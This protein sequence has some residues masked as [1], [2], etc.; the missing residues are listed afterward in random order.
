MKN[1][2]ETLQNP[3]DALLNVLSS[4]CGGRGHFPNPEVF[5]GC[6]HNVGS[7]TLHAE[8]TLPPHLCSLAPLQAL[9]GRCSNSTDCTISVCC[10]YAYVQL[11]VQLQYQQPSVA[12]LRA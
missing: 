6:K 1:L 3:R 9:R 7:V 11:S 5:H 10:E 4:S 12:L 2:A 8:G